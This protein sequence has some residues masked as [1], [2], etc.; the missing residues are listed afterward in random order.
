MELQPKDMNESVL[1]LK[2]KRKE[3]KDLVI[4]L[5]ISPEEPSSSKEDG[6]VSS[7]FLVLW[8]LSFLCHEASRAFY[9]PKTNQ[10]RQIFQK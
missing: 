2:S 3:K 9:S 5:L 4:L 7:R 6:N 1:Q 10:E 8:K